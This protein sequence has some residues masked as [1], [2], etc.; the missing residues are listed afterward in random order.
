M[1][2]LL[3]LKAWL[4]LHDAARYLTQIFDEEVTEADM[5]QF[6]LE[7]NL[8]LSVFFVNG[9]YAC[10][11]I[12]VSL[13]QV[14]WQDVPSLDG[15][16]I[17]KIPKGGRVFRE[18][19]EYFQVQ[20]DVIIPISDGPWDLP[21]SGGERVDV[22]YAFQRLTSGHE[23]TAIS[24]DGVMVQSSSNDLFELQRRFEDSYHPLGDAKNERKPFFDPSCFHPA[25]ALPKDS[26]FIVRTSAL[27]DLVRRANNGEP[28]NGRSLSTTER[29]SLLRLVI[30]MA[31]RGYGYDPSAI[32]SAIPRQIADDLE[33]CGID[34]SDDTVRAYLKEAANAFLSCDPSKTGADKPKSV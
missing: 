29:N 4:T 32:R 24:L 31:V 11:C 28:K 34:M 9:T 33:S 13:E 6:A 21:M 12:P 5:L 16:E 3:K 1:S 17:L 15:A 20:S 10:R 8:R 27:M 14:E 23:V 7:G 19:T 2:K 30:G 18:G 22:E 26:T 25:G